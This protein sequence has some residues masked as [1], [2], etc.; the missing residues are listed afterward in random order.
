[1]FA[2]EYN[3]SEEPWLISVVEFVDTV[4]VDLLV[5]PIVERGGYVEPA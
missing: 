5:T 3:K 4:A 2:A 1:M